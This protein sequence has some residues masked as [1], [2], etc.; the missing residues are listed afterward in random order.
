[1]SASINLSASD[2]PQSMDP[3]AAVNLARVLLVD[4]AVIN[5][6]ILRTFLEESVPCIDEA[7]DGPRALE[8]FK[9][10][11]YAAVLLDIE[12]PGMDGYDTLRE[13]RTWEREE[14]RPRTLVVAV[15]SSD[16]PEDEQR[17]LAAGADAYLTKPVKRKTLWAALQSHHA[18]RPCAA[19]MANLL[20]QLLAYAS[21][22]L[23]EIATTGFRDAEAAGKNLHA[24]RGALAT[25]GFEGPATRLKQIQ[26]AVKRGEMPAPIVFDEIRKEI[27]C[28]AAVPQD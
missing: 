27:Q 6:E 11:G 4:D 8:L 22:M 13:M 9:Q 26:Q 19:A 3:T 14:G 17:I 10:H 2:A 20:P 7:A 1:M 21:A 23:D 24:L 16:F 12:M 5:R 25:F 15:T 18:S 28:L